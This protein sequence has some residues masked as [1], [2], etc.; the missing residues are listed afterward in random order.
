MN[1]LVRVGTTSAYGY[2]LLVTVAPGLL[3]A[4]LRGVYFE[5]VGVIITLILLG[6]LFEA[7]AKAGTGEAIRQLIGMQPRTARLVRDGSEADVPVEDVVPGDVISVRPGEKVPVDGE[8]IDGHSTVDQSMVTG[9]PI[10]ATKQIGDTV[11]GAK[12]NQTC[13]LRFD[14]PR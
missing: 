1:A 2:S 12:S 14:A 9:E 4:E 10:P 7:R 3:P 13:A 11:I 8:V 5:V 6:R